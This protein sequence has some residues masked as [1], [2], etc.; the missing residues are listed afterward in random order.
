MINAVKEIIIVY[1]EDETKITNTFYGK[2]AD[3]FNMTVGGR[4]HI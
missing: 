4:N 3:L 2:I 1:S